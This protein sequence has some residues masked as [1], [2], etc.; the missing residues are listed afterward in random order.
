[1]T[2]SKNTENLLKMKDKLSY[3]DHGV[4]KYLGQ[5]IL[6]DDTQDFNVLKDGVRVK[7]RYNKVVWF[8]VHG[9]IPEKDEFLWHKNLNTLDCRIE[10]LRLLDRETHL[11]VKEAQ[12]NLNQYL[13]YYKSKKDAL[14][15]ILE[16][17][18]NGR[19]KKEVHHDL[20]LVQRR[21]RRLQLIFTKVLSKYCY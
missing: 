14:S 7:M 20:G 6:P 21:F 12:R 3:H 18:I 5:T 19:P 16:Y 8:V 11:K 4:V 2:I 17:R 1:M 10:N 9:H 15:Y 13:K